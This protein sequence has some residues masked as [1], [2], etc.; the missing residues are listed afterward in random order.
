MSERCYLAMMT[1]QIPVHVLVQGLAKVQGTL[2]AWNMTLFE[3]SGSG[4]HGRQRHLEAARLPGPRRDNG[5][6]AIRRASP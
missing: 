3:A 6:D 2:G 1:A 4:P 5:I